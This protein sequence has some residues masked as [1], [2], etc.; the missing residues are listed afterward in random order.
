MTQGDLTT[1]LGWRDNDGLTTTITDKL[2]E[3]MREENTNPQSGILHHEENVDLLPANLELSAME[4]MLVTTMSRET[5]MRNYLSKPKTAYDY[6]FDIEAIRSDL[7]AIGESMGLTHIIS[8]DG[9]E[10]TPSN[11]SWATPVTASK[12]FQG[13]NLKRK[14]TDYV[15]SM[16]S[17]LSSYGGATIEYFTIYI[18]PLDG[19]SYRIYFLY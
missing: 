10:I 2:S 5:V 17:I 19:G 6:A 12:S 3:I 14:L 18:E 16:P 1:C 8:D 11:S 9:T 7:I 4:M 15:Q 13:E